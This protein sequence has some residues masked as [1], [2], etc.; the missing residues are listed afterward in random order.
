VGGHP[1]L[2]PRQLAD[3][4]HPIHGGSRP[5]GDDIIVIDHGQRIP[6]GTAEELEQRIGGER[7]EVRVDADASVADA[8]RIR[9]NFTTGELRRRC[10]GG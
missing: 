7:M 10:R 8:R 2:S 1:D 6:Q 9:A 4:D 3:N 5:V